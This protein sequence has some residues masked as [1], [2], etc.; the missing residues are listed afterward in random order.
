M[1]RDRSVAQILAQ[2]PSNIIHTSPDSWTEA[3]GFFL[4]AAAN[5]DNYMHYRS[6]ISADGSLK[7]G[8]EDLDG[9]GDQDFDDM[10]FTIARN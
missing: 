6:Y 10:L 3:C 7:H 9:G 5:P 4:H 1:L 8:F 2:I